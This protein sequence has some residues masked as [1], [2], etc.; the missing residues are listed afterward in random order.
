MSIDEDFLA[1][2]R[3]PAT[4]KPLRAMTPQERDALGAAIRAGGVTTR[5]G[6]HVEEAIPE[7][8]VPEDEQFVYPIDEGIPILLTEEAIPLPAP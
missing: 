5:G 2:L 4:H 6:R 1:K 3:C 7:G 8:L